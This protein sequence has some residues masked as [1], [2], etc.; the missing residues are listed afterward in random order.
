M[1]VPSISERMPEKVCV[2]SAP[3]K[4]SSSKAGVEDRQERVVKPQTAM[5][6]T[7]GFAKTSSRDL[8]DYLLFRE[9]DV[10]YAHNESPLKHKL[11]VCVRW[12]REWQKASLSS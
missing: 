5:V 8:V 9:F 4:P 1:S 11:W 2:E 12:R 10:C 6:R 3:E 7:I